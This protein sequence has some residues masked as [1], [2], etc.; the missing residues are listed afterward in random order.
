[1]AIGICTRVRL[2]ALGTEL[3]RASPFHLFARPLFRSRAMCGF[4]RLIPDCGTRARSRPCLVSLA[5]PPHHVR[6]E[7][8][9][10][11]RRSPTGRP[12]ISWTVPS[13]SVRRCRQHAHGYGDNCCYRAVLRWPCD[14]YVSKRFASARATLA[15]SSELAEPFRSALV[16]GMR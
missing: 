2:R 5:S 9:C 14:L 11:R 3:L 8:S 10:G 4:L 12:S 16:P 7:A 13:S 1:M 15:L 6:W